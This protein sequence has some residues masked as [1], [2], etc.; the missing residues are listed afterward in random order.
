VNPVIIQIKE[1]A[2]EFAQDKELAKLLREN[3]LFPAIAKR[4]LVILNFDGV[5]GATQSFIHALIGVV[6]QQYGEESLEWLE[7]KN[8]QSGVKSI[9][10]TVIE[11]SLI[12]ARKIA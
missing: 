10:L 3:I 11:Y 7:F 9:I 8:C 4:N 12:P 5:T 6:L 2:G 1:Q